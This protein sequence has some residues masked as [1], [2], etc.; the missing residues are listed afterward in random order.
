MNNLQDSQKEAIANF[1][2]ITETWDSEQA[3]QVLQ[4]YNWDVTQA[5]NEFL[6]SSPHLSSSNISDSSNFSIPSQNPLSIFNSSQNSVSWGKQLSQIFSSIW[7]SIVPEAIRG[8]ISI[9]A[10]EFSKKMTEICLAP[11]N[12]SSLRFQELLSHCH[13]QNLPLFIYLHAFSDEY[14]QELFSDSRLVSFLNKEYLYWGVEHNSDEGQMLKKLLNIEIFPFVAIIQVKNPKTPLVLARNSGYLD[15]RQLIII[16]ENHS[17]NADPELLQERRLRAQQ[18]EELKEAERIMMMQERQAKE[19]REEEKKAQEIKEKQKQ[20]KYEI[21]KRNVG[22]EPQPSEI[23]ALVS[24]RLAAGKRLDRNFEKN[25]KVSVL[26]DYLEMNDVFA[27]ELVFGFPSKSLT[28]R[29]KSL[30][31][32]G[33]YPKCVIHVREAN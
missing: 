28:D 4:R 19:K 17:N 7:K 23:T 15:V 8:E 27:T 21:L 3:M 20:E 2:A 10:Q 29:E 11:V 31:D 5:S 6:S 12:F 1:Q 24:F 22:S 9:P 13:D 30:E 18:Q 32:E 33:V 26:Y 14:P 16:L 25:K